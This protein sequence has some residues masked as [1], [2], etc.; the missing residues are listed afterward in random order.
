MCQTT[1]SN[2]SIIED[3]TKQAGNRRRCMAEWRKRLAGAQSDV[4]ALV[5]SVPA[6]VVNKKVYT[7]D[8]S[9]SRLETVDD[10]IREVIDFWFQTQTSDRPARNFFS[11]YTGEA[12][13]AASADSVNNT[14][15]LSSQFL[16]SG[17]LSQLSVEQ[18]FLSDY[19]RRRI[20]LV[21]SRSFNEMK[22]FSGTTATDLARVLSQV[23]TD[24]DSPRRAQ[25][26]IRDRF[27]VADSRAE[28]IA[29]TEINRA[30]TVS[31]TEQADENAEELGITIM[32]M[33]RSSLI[34]DRTRAWHAARHGNL[35]TTEDQSLWW[36]GG[37]N[38]ISCLCSISEVPLDED[39]QPHDRGLIDRMKKQK[40]LFV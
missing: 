28:R 2:A 5:G 25:K 19:Y 7:W 10:R 34:P 12:A 4:L 23:V 37:S 29:R 20:E 38:R 39:G 6:I 30:Y 24:G 3:P 8:V 13:R 14:L 18:M 26:L 33:H 11:T 40:E 17:Q 21:Y 9:G 36:D 32:V 22:G 27:N 16:N 31:R 15:L 35:Y 1:T